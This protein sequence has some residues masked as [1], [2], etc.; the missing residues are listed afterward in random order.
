MTPDQLEIL[1]RLEQLEKKVEALESRSK[2]FNPPTREE[3]KDYCVERKNSVDWNKW[4][5]HY[6]ANGWMIGKTKM[7]S[8]QAA[9]RTWENKNELPLVSNAVPDRKIPKNYGVPTKTSITYAEYKAN[10]TKTE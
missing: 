6:T 3:V 2:R 1:S 7:K 4:Y 8:W 9:V 10:K 5:D